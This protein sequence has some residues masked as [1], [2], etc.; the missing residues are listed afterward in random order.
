MT[1]D[2]VPI[3]RVLHALGGPILAAEQIDAALAAHPAHVTVSVPSA[4]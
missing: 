4:R 2:D 3:G 1:A